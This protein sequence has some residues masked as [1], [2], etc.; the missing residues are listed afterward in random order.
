MRRPVTVRAMFQL[1]AKLLGW[2]SVDAK[3]IDQR[4]L[5]RGA[6]Q[7]DTAGRTPYQVWEYMVELPAEQ[8]VPVRLTIEEKTFNLGHPGPQI[9]EP[10][11]VLV[12]RKRTRAVFNLKDPRLDWQAARK[13]REERVKAEDEARF[14]AKLEGLDEPENRSGVE[15]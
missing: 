14:Q 3:L 5:R 13:A 7:S 4:F 10:V 8:G 9:G 12:N 1:G 2:N 6:Y 11:P 15:R